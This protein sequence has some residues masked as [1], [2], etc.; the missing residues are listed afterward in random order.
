MTGTCE[1]GLAPAGLKTVMAMS[2]SRRVLFA[3]APDGRLLVGVAQ[4]F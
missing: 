3:P 2:M 4:A 1:V